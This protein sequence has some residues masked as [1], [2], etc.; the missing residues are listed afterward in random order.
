MLKKLFVI[1]AIALFLI[2]GIA[3]AGQGHGP[4]GYYEPS[5]TGAIKFFKNGHP[6]P[7]SEWDLVQRYRPP[8]FGGACDD[9][10]ALAE[11]GVMILSEGTVVDNDHPMGW[12]WAG[13]KNL[14]L[15]GKAFAT[16]EDKRIWFFKIPGY[17]W[18]NV[19]LRMVARIYTCVFSTGVQTNGGLS[20]TYAL[21]TGILDF[22]GNAIAIGSNGCPQWARVGLH[23]IFITGVGAYSQS[24]SSNGYGSAATWGQG[25]TSVRVSG[26][27]SD[28]DTHGFL[29]AA[30]FASIDG[31]VIVKQG[32]FVSS[33]VSPDGTTTA[34][35]GMVK[36]GYAM[37][38]GDVNLEGIR[39]SGSVGQAGIAQD[40]YGAV[41]QGNSYAQF[42][43]A[44]GTINNG[45]CIDYANGSGIAVVTGYNNVT[46]TGNKVV[47]TSK[48]T[49]LAISGNIGISQ[50][51]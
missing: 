40:G 1:A 8:C 38:F 16:G 25:T 17:A 24:Q 43:G 7:R 31:K 3:L 47:I 48:Q 36:G 42:T 29:T 18:A 27:D 34:N 51:Q 41:A 6:G 13:G 20:L 22:S 49:A 35:F 45:R 5:Q 11:A 9:A 32:I 15:K 28:F 37:S 46:N 2:P 4:S 44:K 30:A 21:S 33:Y 26:H 50:P 39:S 23:G 10:L 12:G 14:E 19:D